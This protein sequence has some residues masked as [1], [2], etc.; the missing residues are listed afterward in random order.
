MI[1]LF[2]GI[3]LHGICYDFFFVTGFMYTDKVAPKAVSGQAQS[4]LVFITQGLGMLIGFRF[5]GKKFAETVPKYAELDEA[6]KAARPDSD[7]SFGEKLGKLFSINMPESVNADLLSSTM[8]QW[9]EFWILPAIFAA[10]IAVLFFLAFW[11]KT[12]VTE[13]DLEDM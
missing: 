7:L 6:I 4:L 9:K 1:M 13:E 2:I 10:G 5:A 3:A 8:E 12:K 11:D